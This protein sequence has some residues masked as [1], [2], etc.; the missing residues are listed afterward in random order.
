[1]S[2]KRIEEKDKKLDEVADSMAEVLIQEVGYTDATLVCSKMQA[3]ILEKLSQC[4]LGKSY[5]QAMI[6]AT[7][8]RE[9]GTNEG[10]R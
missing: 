10:Y 4:K 5:E 3:I 9:E 2:P 8:D 6:D 1:M 7:K